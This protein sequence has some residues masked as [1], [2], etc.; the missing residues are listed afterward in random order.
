ML[1]VWINTTANK[2]FII[3]SVKI[4]FLKEVF[5]NQKRSCHY[6]LSKYSAKKGKTKQLISYA[7]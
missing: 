5:P 7:L 3:H 1:S 2:T 6:L 4:F